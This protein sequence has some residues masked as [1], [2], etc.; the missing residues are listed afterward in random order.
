MTEAAHNLGKNIKPIYENPSAKIG[1]NRGHSRI[2]M[3]GK[4]LTSCGFGNKGEYH[5]NYG[6]GIIEVLRVEGKTLPKLTRKVAGTVDRPIIDLNSSLGSEALHGTHV[7]IT[8]NSG[9]ITIRTKGAK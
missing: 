3:Q 9:N 8:A 4:W 7:V 1:L 6:Q 5:V 2:W